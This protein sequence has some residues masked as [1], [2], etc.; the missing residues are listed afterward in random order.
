MLKF[1]NNWKL[2]L[3]RNKYF[4]IL[5]VFVDVAVF[6]FRCS[7][8][9]VHQ[10]EGRKLE[11]LGDDVILELQNNRDRSEQL[12][13]RFLMDDTSVQNLPIPNLDAFHAK[14]NLRKIHG[15]KRE[16]D[17][18]FMLAMSYNKQ[19]PTGKT[20]SISRYC[21]LKFKLCLLWI[22]SAFA[23]YW[24]SEKFD[25]VRAIW[26]GENLISRSGRVFNAPQEFTKDLP[27]NV[28]LDGELYAGR[29]KFDA[30]RSIANSKHLQ[31]RWMDELIFVVYDM[32]S[33]KPWEERLS[34]I[35]MLFRTHNMKHAVAAPQQLCQGVYFMFFVLAFKGILCTWYTFPSVAQALNISN[36]KWRGL[37]RKGVR[38]SCCVA[39]NRSITKTDQKAC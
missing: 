8:N 15:Q 16:I 6:N 36:K 9:E 29:G 23:G 1:I 10:P 2:T 26:D 33:T 7:S 27:T 12:P 19:D 31:Q 22:A 17:H 11:F 5:Y 13:T 3:L 39:R 14:K 37:R 32:L 18:L 4:C 35:K 20:H 24:M 38:A 34:D 30:A 21:E 25:G 28:I